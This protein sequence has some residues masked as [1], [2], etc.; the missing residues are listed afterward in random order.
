[1]QTASNVHYNLY[2]RGEPVHGLQHP[3][4]TTVSSQ[5]DTSRD[6]R[7][8]RRSLNQH[9]LLNKV[10]LY[11]TEVSSAYSESHPMTISTAHPNSLFQHFVFPTCP[12]ILLLTSLNFLQFEFLTFCSLQYV[13]NREK[14]I[15]ISFSNSLSCT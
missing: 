4:N 14:K 2:S 13:Y 15:F 3:F 5:L 11:L 10:E 9:L 12:R 7:H 6:G 1:M 8:P